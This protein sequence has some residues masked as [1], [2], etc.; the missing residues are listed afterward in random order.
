MNE[1]RAEL[2]E[3]LGGAVCKHC[4]IS[5][6]R[7]LQIDHIFGNG[8][9]IPLNKTDIVDLYLDNPYLARKELQVLCCNCHRIKSLE[10]GDLGRRK[11]QPKPITVKKEDI[12][13]HILDE[14]ERGNKPITVKKNIPRNNLQNMDWY[15]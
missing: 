9:D 2:I 12:P 10:N 1:K 14:L 7:I 6:T 4:K 15:K 3:V 13:E 8:Q 11:G 5:D